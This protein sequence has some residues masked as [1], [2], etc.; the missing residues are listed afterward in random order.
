[1]LTRKPAGDVE[2]EVLVPGIDGKKL[3]KHLS[4]EFGIALDI[5][6]AEQD[7]EREIR[8]TGGRAE[9][10]YIHRRPFHAKLV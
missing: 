2:S 8:L 6:G 3:L 7:R 4:R 5:G 9:K 10:A 1:M